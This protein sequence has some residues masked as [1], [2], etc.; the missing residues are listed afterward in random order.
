MK[1]ENS[2]MYKKLNMK[3]NCDW[4]YQKA[5]ELKALFAYDSSVI[6]VCNKRRALVTIDSM[7][8]SLNE[9]KQYIENMYI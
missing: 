4:I 3:A 6:I 1:G 7:I 8:S 2:K 5:K 9:L